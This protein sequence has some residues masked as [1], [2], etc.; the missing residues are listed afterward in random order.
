MQ[1]SDRDHSAAGGDVRQGSR[2]LLGMSMNGFKAGFVL[3]GLVSVVLPYVLTH[4]L[5]NRLLYGAGE[6]AV[7]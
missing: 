2:L 6:E 4:A 1:G 7:V 5:N 3:G